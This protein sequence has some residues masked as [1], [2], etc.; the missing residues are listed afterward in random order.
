MQNT[1]ALYNQIISG[2]HWTEV[3]V[4]ID[5]VF[6]GMKKLISVRTHRAAFG[7][8]TP[9][10][11]LAVAGEIEVTLYGDWVWMYGDAESGFAEEARV[12][13]LWY[14]EKMRK[15]LEGEEAGEEVRE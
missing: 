1:S 12:E 3:R 9:T 10:P 4:R 8:G 7:E 6:Y 2:T 14:I 15:L 13:I 5:G 11:G